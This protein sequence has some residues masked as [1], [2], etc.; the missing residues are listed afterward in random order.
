MGLDDLK[1][2]VG[3]ID[4]LVRELAASAGE[5]ATGL[6]QVKVA[7][8]Q[9]GQGVQ[10]NAAMIEEATAVSH[11]L[12]TEIGGLMQMMGRFQVSGGQA[13]AAVMRRAA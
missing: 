3:E 12:K 1:I 6:D 7:V 9:M 4:A 10:Q 8:N 5:Q 2:K 13:S 11:A